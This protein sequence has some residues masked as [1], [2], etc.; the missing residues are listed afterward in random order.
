MRKIV[1]ML[2]LGVF[3]VGASNL[4]AWDGQIQQSRQL[5]RSLY[6]PKDLKHFTLGFNE[7]VADTL[8]V[9]F[10]Q[11]VD[12]CQDG[13]SFTE[14]NQTFE[15]SRG[16]APGEQE[17]FLDTVLGEEMRPPKCQKGWA[18]NMLDAVSELAP[19]FY[20]PYA[21]GGSVLSILAE[22]KEGAALIYEKGL[23]VFPED[24]HLHYRLA[25]H[26]LYELRQLEPAAA[27]MRKA[28]LFGAPSWVYAL[29]GRLYSEAGQREFGIRVL[30]EALETDVSRFGGR[31]RIEQRLKEL[32][33]QRPL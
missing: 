31:E 33:S 18:Y 15:A 10:L 19:K 11:D 14:R 1:Y 9:R 22:D 28:A 16:E 27:H 2:L 8:W 23:Q 20:L 26:Y 25:Y 5:K 4:L 24:W 6:P 29:A 12:L 30:K 32:E 17:T 7:V 13:M 3:F 21:F